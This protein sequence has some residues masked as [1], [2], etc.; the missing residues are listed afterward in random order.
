MKKLYFILMLTSITFSS[1]I[2]IYLAKEVNQPYTVSGVVTGNSYAPLSE[3]VD[4]KVELLKKEYDF[5][6]IGVVQVVL[7]NQFA[8]DDLYKIVEMAKVEARA[9]GGN[10]ISLRSS[11]LVQKEVQESTAVHNSDGIIVDHIDHTTILYNPKYIFVVG[12]IY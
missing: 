6:E 3:T 12:K 1:C 5:E 10:F 11:Q 8:E 9:M 7:K 2:P 4:V